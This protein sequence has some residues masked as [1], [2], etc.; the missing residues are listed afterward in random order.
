M[1][2]PA[3]HMS[4]SSLFLRVACIQFEPVF[5]Q[6]EAS[7]TRADELVQ[8]SVRL[9]CPV[10]R[11]VE[12]TSTI[13]LYFCEHSLSVDAALLNPVWST[14]SS[15]PRWLSPVFETQRSSNPCVTTLLTFC[16]VGY[17]FVSRKDIEP[18]VEEAGKGPSV[19]WARSKGGYWLRLFLRP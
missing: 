4:S 2:S 18:F 17:S 11:P 16:F 3:T 6:V 15:Y 9:S 1:S 13:A 7:L 8:R 10:Q 14:C 19:T 5:K 12:K